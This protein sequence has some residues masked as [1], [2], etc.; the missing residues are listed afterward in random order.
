[1]NKVERLL[2]YIDTPPEASLYLHT[3]PPATTVKA[4]SKHH[5]D[6]LFEFLQT[7]HHDDH[8]ISDDW[9]SQGTIDFCNVSMKYREDLDFVL[10]GVNVTFQGKEKIG[11]VGRTGAG[12]SSLINV[13][14]R[15][16]ELH[17][18]RIEIDGIDISTIGTSYSF[19]T[20]FLCLTF[21]KKPIQ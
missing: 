11:V 15:L 1:M 16:T 18:G 6:D 12:K 14:F 3:L 13:L 19:H 4:N 5:K 21:K 7:D 17:E 8:E 20:D 10:K 2:H 9:P